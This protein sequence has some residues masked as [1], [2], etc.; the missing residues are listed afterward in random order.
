MPYRRAGLGPEAPALPAVSMPAL[1][2][3][4]ADAPHQAQRSLDTLV[5]SCR[6]LGAWGLQGSAKFSVLDGDAPVYNPGD[7]KY[8][9]ADTPRVVLRL[10]SI[11]ITPGHVVGL[12]VVA[13]PSG[14]TQY[15]PSTN[16]WKESGRGGDVRA[17]VTYRNG[18]AQSVSATAVVTPTASDRIYG[19]EPANG[20]AA[21]ETYSA[22]A[23]P[24]GVV[25]SAVDREKF[26]R[27]GDVVVDVVVTYT[28]SVRVVDFAIV[29]RPSAIVVDTTSSEWPSNMYSAGGSAYEELPSE[30][31][32]TQLTTTDPGGGLEACRRALEQHGL[33]LGPCLAWQSSGR[34]A[35]GNMLTWLDYDDGTGDDEA[36]ALSS[37]SSSYVVM[38]YLAPLS[39]A[40]FPGFPL[41]GYARQARDSDEFLD[42]CTGVLPV[43]AVVYARATAGVFKWQA[44]MNEWSAI[45]L[46]VTG[47]TWGWTIRPGW[48]ETGIS[49]EDAPL[50]RLL[51]KDTGGATWY[52][53]YGGLFHRQR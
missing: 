7:R 29:E 49:P 51:G 33:Q 47:L 26:A 6:V 27:G 21:L 22:T 30:Y 34:E 46:P 2:M 41:G 52:W 25:P 50:A 28:G 35:T 19:A 40:Q 38:P 42:G 31:P 20:H 24:F 12:D 18:D 44:G 48:I 3:L 39:S 37:S 23:N 53:R 9:D 11:P 13:L 32:V 16:D 8:P 5:S 15:Q 14:P 4:E 1:G 17:T 43:W 45:T 36:P 10:Y